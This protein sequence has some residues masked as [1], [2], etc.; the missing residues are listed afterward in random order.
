MLSEENYD[1][2]LE[3]MKRNRYLNMDIMEWVFYLHLK[4][5]C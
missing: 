4:N 3:L 1:I 2:E 5:Q